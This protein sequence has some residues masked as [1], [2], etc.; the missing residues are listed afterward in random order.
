MFLE[1]IRED[2]VYFIQAS[3]ESKKKQVLINKIVHVIR[4]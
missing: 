2:S 4:Q 1:I 3:T